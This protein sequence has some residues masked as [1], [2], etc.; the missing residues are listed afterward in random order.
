MT[1]RRALITATGVMMLTAGPLAQTKTTE[2]TGKALTGQTT[3][4]GEVVLVD[5]N[6]LLVRMQPGSQYPHLQRSRRTTV[7]HRRQA[8]DR[9]RTDARNRPHG[10]R[11]DSRTAGD[12]PHDDRH[13]RNGGVRGQEHQPPDCETGQRREPLVRR[14]AGIPIHRRREASHDC[15][16]PA[17]DEAVR[18]E[19]HLGAE[20]RALERDRRYRQVAQVGDL[21]EPGG[22]RLRPASDRRL[23]SRSGSSLVHETRDN[24]RGRLG[25]SVRTPR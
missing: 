8:E 7:H 20:D 12:R 11:H 2:N 10:H 23:S 5:G 16:T 19:D 24:T 21:N 13:E 3:M 22:C 4:T 15:G 25:D 17:G 18:D 1:L 6:N 9:P 14:A